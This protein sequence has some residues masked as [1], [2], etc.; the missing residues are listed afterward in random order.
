M[1]RALADEDDSVDGVIRPM[2]N[3]FV[4]FSTKPGA[5]AYLPDE[6]TKPT[7]FTQALCEQMDHI[8]DVVQVFRG[9]NHAVFNA[10]GPEQEPWYEES[11]KMERPA[12]SVHSR[13]VTF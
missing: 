11:I 2:N 7:I 6:K 5:Y 1:K 9:V 12:D 10:S 4:M 8:S 3:M 13:L